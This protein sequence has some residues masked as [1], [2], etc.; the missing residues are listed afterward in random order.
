LGIRLE[1]SAFPSL[2]G[3][4]VTTNTPADRHHREHNK[5]QDEKPKE[6]SKGQIGSRL[7]TN[8]SHQGRD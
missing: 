2:A 5:C 8:L 4:S 3:W 1:V 7:K 6:D